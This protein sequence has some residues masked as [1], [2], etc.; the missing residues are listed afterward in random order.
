MN[1]NATAQMVTT[2]QVGCGKTKD[3]ELQKA[4]RLI[5]NIARGLGKDCTIMFL[6]DSVTIAPPS[7]SGESSGENLYW[8]IMDAEASK[9]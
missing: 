1:S 7:W 8:A 4:C 3:T 9:L 5:E 2:T 6:R